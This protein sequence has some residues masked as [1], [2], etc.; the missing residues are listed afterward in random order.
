MNWKKNLFYVLLFAFTFCFGGEYVSVAD[1]RKKGVPVTTAFQQA[2]DSARKLKKPLLVPSGYYALEDTVTV[3]TDVVGIGHPVLHMRNPEKVIMKAEPW[4][5]RIS[6]LRF[7]GGKD[8]LLLGNKNI[9]QSFFVIK[10]CFFNDAS[11]C[12]IRFTPTASAF[13]KVDECAF[14]DCIQAFI[15]RSDLVYFS[16]SWISTSRKNTKSLAVIEN[17]GVLVCENILGVPR[18][19]GGSD[20]RW[21]DNYGNLTCRNFRFGGEG[22]GFTPVVNYAKYEPRLSGPFVV[23]ENCFATA[24]GNPNRKAA[25]YCEEYPSMIT[26]RDC[27]LAGIPPVKLSS[28]V[29]KKDYFNDAN[30]G[31]VSFDLGNNIGEFAK[32]VPA[33]FRKRLADIKPKKQIFAPGEQLSSAETERAL[34]NAL[35]Q[36]SKIP[37]FKDGWTYQKHTRKTTPGTFRSIT[38]KSNPWFTGDC[39][40]GIKDLCSDFL[41]VAGSG[42]QTVIVYRRKKSSYPHVRIQNVEVDL[43]KMPYLTWRLRDTKVNGGHTSVKVVDK[44]TGKQVTL[45]EDYGMSQF[46]YH[47]Y[48]LRKVF[49]KKSGKITIDI[50]FYLCA[51]R[52]IK[53]MPPYLYLQPGD[54]YLIDF[55]RLEAE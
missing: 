20:L 4:R 48:D 24:V 27:V 42:E 29:Q 47:A 52:I 50:K 19:A 11:G 36:I 35:S 21:I 6:G 14:R 18:V 26:I 44:A 10:D 51:S 49:G 54:F 3:Y 9:D 23:L 39:L 12:A 34:K 1:F 55:L 25:V 22:G 41:A 5:I 30:P 28:K 2:A 31:M 33:G 16:N 37:P 38:T 53:P 32:D 43:D 8:S 46:L 7:D 17:H 40:D 45:K 13:V 15:A